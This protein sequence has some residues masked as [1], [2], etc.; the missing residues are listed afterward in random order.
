MIES[1]ESVK[2]YE[3]N[4]EVSS[5]GRVVSL[6]RKWA[7][8]R[9]MLKGCVRGCGY[10]TVGLWK[11]SKHKLVNVH[12]LVA[13]HFISNDEDLPCVNH[14]DGNKLNN[15]VRNLEWCTYSENIKHGY[16][17]GR[18]PKVRM[19]GESNPA[20][21]LTELD[22]RE[23]KDL[24]AGDWSQ[25]KL[26]NTFGVSQKAIHNIVNGHSWKHLQE[27]ESDCEKYAWE[28]LQEVKDENTK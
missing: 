16:R 5:F 22:V 21:K 17:I 19:P 10:N 25:S 18:H 13:E 11:N 27:Q 28:Y 1:W 12:R 15:N 23:I 20:S 24:Y 2:Y 3:G 26:A 9:V 7:P 14:K 4:Y 8:D 6:P